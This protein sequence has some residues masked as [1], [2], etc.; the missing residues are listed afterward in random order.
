MLFRSITLW[1][2]ETISTRP[3]TETTRIYTVSSRGYTEEITQVLYKYFEIHLDAVNRDMLNVFVAPD[4]KLFSEDDPG[5]KRATWESEEKWATTD[6]VGAFV[7]KVPRKTR[8]AS[9]RA[10]TLVSKA[11]LEELARA[12]LMQFGTQSPVHAYLEVTGRFDTP[13]AIVLSTLPLHHNETGDYYELN[14]R[15]F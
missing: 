15:L 12:Q 1:D 3:L 14:L 5:I 13:E 9:I 6:D 4:K 7:V 11:I 2:N 10:H 8:E